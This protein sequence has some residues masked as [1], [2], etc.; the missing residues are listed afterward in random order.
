MRKKR[1]AQV[2]GACAQILSPPAS[3]FRQQ[4]K[5]APA[6]PG[7]LLLRCCKRCNG[8]PF[9][10][11]FPSQ[12][13]QRRLHWIYISHYFPTPKWCNYCWFPLAGGRKEGKKAARQERSDSLSSPAATANN[14]NCFHQC[15]FPPADWI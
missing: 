14:N 4:H 3:H 2:R 6:P 11:Y 5:T 10:C 1:K 15:A 13:N 9:D 8:A 12:R 7:F